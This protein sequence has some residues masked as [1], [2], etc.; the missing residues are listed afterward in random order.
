MPEVIRFYSVADEYGEFSNFA[1][2]PIRL[3]KRTWPTTEHYFQAMKFENRRD[4]DE[5]RETKSPMV[6]A[7][8][9][10]SRKRKL[11]KGWERSRVEV[12]RKALRAKF[13]QHEDLQE[14]LLDTGDAEIVEHTQRDSFW[15]DGGD[16]SGTNMLGKLLM[17]IRDELAEEQSD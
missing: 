8:K 13:T 9:G 5:I 6:A 1:S 11:R 3:E 14:L 15:G 17:Q 4:Q 16:G 7:R 2:Y 12:M 10:R